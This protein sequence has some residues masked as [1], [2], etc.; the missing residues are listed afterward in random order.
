[1]QKKFAKN[2]SIYKYKS[3]KTKQIIHKTS[4]VTTNNIDSDHSTKLMKVEEQCQRISS[5]A[6]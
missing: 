3:F 6:Y 5:F 4:T 2:V 1:M